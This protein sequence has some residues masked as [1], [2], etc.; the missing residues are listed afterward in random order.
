M[1]NIKM[2]VSDLDDTFL[3][4]NS[5]VPE[6]NRAALEIMREK[7]VRFVLASG[8]SHI[9]LD[10][11]V[12]SLGLKREGEYGIAIQGGIIYKTL[13][14][15]FVDTAMLPRDLMLKITG[16]V[17]EHPASEKIDILVYDPQSVLHSCK[18]SAGFKEYF[19]FTKIPHKLINT[20]DDFETDALK[21]LLKGKNEDLKQIEAHMKQYLD[22]SYNMFY[23]K[24]IYLEF[25]QKNATKGK[26]AK[27]LAKILGFGIDEV[28]AVG[29]NFNDVS[30]VDMAGVGVAVSN[31]IDFLKDRADYVT[32][33]TN[34]DGVLWELVN[35][36]L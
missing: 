31:G 29:D 9:S 6:K 35:K 11:F 1:S 13:D 16:N 36:F 25:T 10:P 8:R 33:T 18:D 3:N 7:N 22:D 34:N 30:M 5:K 17:L 2:I 23:S 14:L 20:F 19:T 24:D 21:I 28:V 12:K 26:A 4:D 32:T 27:R 15:S